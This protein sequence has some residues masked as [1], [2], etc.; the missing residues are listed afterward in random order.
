MTY[1]VSE[2]TLTQLRGGLSWLMDD[3]Y[4]EERADLLKGALLTFPWVQ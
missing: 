3:G 4:S 1:L 2:Q